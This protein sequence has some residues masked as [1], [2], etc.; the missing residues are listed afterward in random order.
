MTTDLE[1]DGINT[2][3]NT[4]VYDNDLDFCKALDMVPHHILY[5]G[6]I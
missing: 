4:L 3:V 6:D 5:V 2:E 1:K